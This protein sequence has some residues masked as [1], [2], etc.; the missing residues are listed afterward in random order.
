MIKLLHVITDTNIGGAGILL[1]NLLSCIDRDR[2]DVKAVIPAGSALEGPIRAT[3]TDV[4]FTERGRDRS[5]DLR[6]VREYRRIFAAEKP[7]IV[8]THG[9]LSARIAAVRE[10]VPVR[11]YTRHCAYPLSRIW[12][13]CPVRRVFRDLDKSL[14][15]SGVAV[16][17]AAKDNLVGMGVDPGRIR[18]I[19]NGSRRLRD[20]AEEE[21]A[22]VRRLA[23]AD[24]N[25]LILVMCARLE[26][27][28]G[29]RVLLDAM[30]LLDGTDVK[31]IFLGDGADADALKEYAWKKGLKDR[32]TFAGF[33]SDTAP[34]MAAADVN[35]NCSI[36]TETSSLAVSEGFS[37]GLPAILSDFGGNPAMAEY[38]G[39][40]VVPKGDANALAGEIKR[41]YYDR[42]ALSTMAEKCRSVYEEHF[43]S[44]AMTRQYE[45]LYENLLAKFGFST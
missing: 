42:S 15:A 6:A 5:F 33:V 2:F 27:V 36:G 32:V 38:G 14:S 24:E 18:V 21:K 41:L 28:K 9:S 22:A 29:H 8:H 7:V 30:S 40:T 3:G 37:A 25:T 1:C 23:G 17:E 34:Y 4:I 16:A 43:T 20:V 35:V 19:I 44:E 26:P 31:A 13:L 10:K 11:V 12:S 39:A 45:E